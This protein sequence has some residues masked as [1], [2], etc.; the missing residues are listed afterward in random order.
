MDMCNYKE[1]FLDL[2]S[3]I[4][5]EGLIWKCPHGFIINDDGNED[6]GENDDDEVSWVRCLS[7]WEHANPQSVRH[8]SCRPRGGS[9][10]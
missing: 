6:G 4:A 3:I 9:I 10:H 5:R 7:A 2:Y 8:Q 1:L